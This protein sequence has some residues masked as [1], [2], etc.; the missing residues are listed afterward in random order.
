MVTRCDRLVDVKTVEGREVLKTGRY[1]RFYGKGDR[2]PVDI[3]GETSIW[4]SAYL[5]GKRDPVLEPSP[6]SFTVALSD[7]ADFSGF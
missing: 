4:L 5:T 7:H 1:L 6:T 2:A 3:A